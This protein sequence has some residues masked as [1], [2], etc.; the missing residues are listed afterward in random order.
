MLV[1]LFLAQAPDSRSP[2]PDC[3]VRMMKA[4]VI[5]SSLVS[6]FMIVRQSFS[7]DFCEDEV[8]REGGLKFPFDCS[9]I[10]A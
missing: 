2:N 9:F 7:T 1:A 10:F 5:C 4:D 8:L 3:M 6:S